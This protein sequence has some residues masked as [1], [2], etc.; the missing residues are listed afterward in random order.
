MEKLITYLNDLSKNNEREWFHAN[1]KRYQESKNTFLSVVDEIIRTMELTDIR[2]Q[3]L[4]AKDTVFRINRDVR[5]SRDKSPYKTHFGSYIAKGGRKSPN[6]GYYLHIEPNQFFIGG[7]VWHPEKEELKAVRQEI[8]FQPE[9]YSATLNSVVKN[10]FTIMEEDKL[11]TGPK[12]FDK[13]SPHIELIKYKSYILSR[14]LSKKELNSPDVASIVAN[15]FS[16]LYPYT[17]FLNTAM[18]FMGNE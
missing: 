9:K 6:A 16:Q 18:D 14:Q 12:D 11:K 4:D 3:D 15:Y 8:M 17:S 13:E 7:G 5:F 1:K 2:L 10:G